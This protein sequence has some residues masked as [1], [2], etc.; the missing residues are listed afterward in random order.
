MSRLACTLVM[1]LLCVGATSC[2]NDTT[3]GRNS[4]DADPFAGFFAHPSSGMLELRRGETEGTYRGEMRADFGPFPVE[5]TRDRDLARGTV[6][7]GGKNHPL[8]LENTRRGLVLTVDGT[9]AEA[10]LQRHENR[11]AYEKRFKARGGY[12][13][14]AADIEVEP[15]TR[16]AK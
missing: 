16:P 14:E 5:L 3:A 15:V 10:P 6:T 8:Q 11:K 4:S 12:Q 2:S 13:G 9:R 7:Y 1:S